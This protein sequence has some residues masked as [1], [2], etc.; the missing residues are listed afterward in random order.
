ML[1]GRPFEY[2][3][4]HEDGKFYSAYQLPYEGISEQCLV[5]PNG[6]YIPTRMIWGD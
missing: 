4:L 1:G 6:F 2:M 3:W 5:Y